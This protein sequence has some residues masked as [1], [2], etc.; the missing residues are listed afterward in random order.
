MDL[1]LLIAL[2]ALVVGIIYIQFIINERNAMEARYIEERATRD[3]Q[4]RIFTRWLVLRLTS[5]Y[6]LWTFTI[7][8]KVDDQ[9]VKLYRHNKEK[10]EFFELKFSEAG[11]DEDH[12]G[13]K[14]YHFYDLPTS[15][16][17]LSELYDTAAGERM[18]IDVVIYNAT[19]ATI[20]IR[21]Q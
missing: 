12:A 4:F 17:T 13:F 19:C 3:R 11:E 9:G 20:L 1:T 21:V 7:D 5:R 18:D 14:V 16:I 15:L 2:F 6:H 8:Q 10:E